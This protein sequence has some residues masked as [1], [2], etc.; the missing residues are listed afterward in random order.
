MKANGCLIGV[1]LG[2]AALVVSGTVE[3][4]N[5]VRN[6]GFEETAASGATAGWSDR[7]PVYRFTNG[8]GRGGSRGLAFDNS[9][10]N[11]YSF[12]TQK[13][14]LQPGCCYSFEVWV[15]TEN[16]KGEESGASVCMEWSGPDG[17]W[18]GGAY[19]DG[20]RGTSDGWQ[21]V[22][23]LTRAIPTNAVRV[24][25]APYVRRGMTGKA[26]FDDLNVSRYYPPLV[27][28]VSASCYRHTAA[29]GTVTFSAGLTLDEAGVKPQEVAGSFVFEA[30]DGKAVRTAKPDA[31]TSDCAKLS[32]DASSFPVGE[33]TVQFALTTLD[34]VSKGMA[35]TRFRRVDK[36]PER[37]AFI[38]AHRRLIVD[39]KPFFP[40]GMYWSSVKEPELEMYGKGPFNCLM[41][42]GS[43]TRQ[44]MD[45]C[46]ARGLKVIYSIKDFY[47]GTRWAPPHMKTE[48]DELAEIRKR[49]DL[50]R[51]HP[52]MLAWYINDEMPISMVSRLAARQRLMEEL[53]PDHPTWVVLYQYDQVRA[54]LSTFDVIGTDPYPIPGKPAG[55]ALEWTRVTHDQTYHSRAVWQVPQVFDWG[56]YR[57]GA[58]R[59][60]SRAPTLLEMR[61]M[62]WQCVA[63]GANGLVFYSFF[64][65][66][67]MKDRDPLVKRWA[68]VCAM[69]EEIKRYIPVM[70]SDDPAPAVTCEGSASVEVRVWGSGSEVYLLAVNSAAEPVTATVTVSESGKRVHAEF[71]QA[72]EL[73]SGGKLVYHFAPL[74]PV[75]VRLD[76][77]P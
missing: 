33:Y 27:S 49:V 16:L 66:F 53:D 29:G 67:K 50:C 30:A 55:M 45:A 75:M 43:P 40:L 62:A 51:S 2:V 25:V 48:A 47:S 10:P 4:E 41:P 14:D 63:A 70:L 15:K 23:G 77:M 54:Y 6:P 76:G 37:K 26:W 38:D 42:Y 8:V 5:A 22:R 71:G 24:T 34:G 73:R 13:L 18:L 69:A 32:V 9:D 68:D 17:K 1:W 39:R 59:E 21:K 20:V 52:A 7:K 44:Q 35:E 72:P 11:F 64:D 3:Q 46:Q 31:L 28:T 65:L 57:K 19:A 56:A 36:L 61:S 60:K 12:P 74:E 58:E